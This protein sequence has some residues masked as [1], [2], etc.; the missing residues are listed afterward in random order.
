MEKRGFDINDR[1]SLERLNGADLYNGL[2]VYT[3]NNTDGIVLKDIVTGE[4]KH[5]PARG[6]GSPRFSPDGRR[7]LFL[8]VSETGGR[9][10][11]IHD[12]AS[13]KTRALTAF[14]GPIMDP[15]WSPDGKRIAFSSISAFGVAK[16][17]AWPDEA[18]AIE[19]LGYKF[20]GRGFIRPDEHMHVYVTDL[21]GNTTALTSGRVDYLMHTWAPDG[22]CLAC[23]SSAE[24]EKGEILGYD[25]FLLDADRQNEPPKRISKGL[26]LVSYPNPIRP[27]FSEDGNSIYMG[28]LKEGSDLQKEYPEV[29]FYRFHT[30][31]S[32]AERV[33]FGDD[34]CI[35]CVQFPY[36]AGCGWG[37]DKAQLYENSIWFVSGFKGVC[38]LYKLDLSG[39]GHAEE[40]LSGKYVINGISP[41]RDGSML[42]SCSASDVPEYCL[43]YNAETGDAHK[44]IE[45]CRE[46]KDTVELSPVYDFFFDTLDGESRVHGFV[47]PPKGMEAGQK[48]PAILYIHGGPHPFYTFGFTPEHQCLSSEGFAVLFCNPRGSSGYGETHQNIAHATDGSAYTDILQFVDEAIRR[49]P[50]IDGARIGVT[51]GSYGGYMTNYLATHC[52]RFQAYVTQRSMSNDL[53]SYASSDMQGT[54]KDYKSFEEFMVNSLKSSTVCYAERIDRPFLILHG[55]ED[56]RTPVYGAH[57][58]YTALKDLH[59]ELPVKM[60]LF[61]HVA[62]DQPS[63]EKQLRVYYS[64][65]V[66]WFKQ[67]L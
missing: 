10:L 16:K 54:S 52:K 45:T 31:G 67:Y 18:I 57:Q 28:V 13:G 42:L 15:I 26:N 35:Q 56:L 3:S 2:A 66:G 36:N 63:D 25:L 40:K 32:G 19:E 24:R 7:I 4:E 23:I 6:A 58:L 43:V 1:L 55:M 65:L 39:D 27:L 37:F 62:H 38:T 5:I 49:Y 44:V 29:Y 48:Y 51:G 61:P 30:D 64:E 53:I 34:T 12:I 22:R 17:K 9:Q 50:F 47:M 41:I 60:V 20:D 33:F 8:A 11:H 59:P 14:R 46:M 21:E